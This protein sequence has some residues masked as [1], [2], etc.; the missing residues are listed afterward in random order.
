[1]FPEMTFKEWLEDCIRFYEESHDNQMERLK[2]PCSNDY[3]K[4]LE[5]TAKVNEGRIAAYK[6]VLAMLIG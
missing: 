6:D 5:N 4:L 2:K 1:M 3:R